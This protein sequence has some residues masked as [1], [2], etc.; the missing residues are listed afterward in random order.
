[1]ITAFKYI[2]FTFIFIF[3]LFYIYLTQIYLFP[4]G[5]VALEK[6]NFVKY[7]YFL[8]FYYIFKIYLYM[9]YICSLS[10]NFRHVDIVA[11]TSI[12]KLKDRSHGDSALSCPYDRL[13]LPN[14]SCNGYWTITEEW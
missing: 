7:I 9:F 5:Y 12:L 8:R 13:T 10:L 6:D 11:H 4:T 3:S 1:M 2:I 14:R